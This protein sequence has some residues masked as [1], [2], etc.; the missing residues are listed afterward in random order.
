M[1]MSAL[2]LGFL[3]EQAIVD[4]CL[5]SQAEEMASFKSFK[6]YNLVRLVSKQNGV[7]KFML[8]RF[9]PAAGML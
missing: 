2:A 8:A 4:T 1:V 6:R 7:E 9:L 3:R 5:D